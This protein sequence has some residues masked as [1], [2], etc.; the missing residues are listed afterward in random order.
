MGQDGPGDRTLRM[1][2][3]WA[4]PYSSVDLG[5]AVVLTYAVNKS[6]DSSNRL[7][8]ICAGDVTLPE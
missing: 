6:L 1:L 2:A 5:D 8:E 4:E 7:S 3:V